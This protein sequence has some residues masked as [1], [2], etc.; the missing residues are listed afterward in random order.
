MEQQLL[1]VAQEELDETLKTIEADQQKIGVMQQEQTFTV[2][3]IK[4]AMCQGID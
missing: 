4:D 2:R 3:Q 1:Q